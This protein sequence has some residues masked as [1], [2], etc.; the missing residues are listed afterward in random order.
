ML[1]H[2]Q[3]RITSSK[4]NTIPERIIRPP[5]KTQPEIEGDSTEDDEDLDVPIKT[6]SQSSI[7]QSQSQSR[8]K[9]PTIEEQSGRT[10][11]SP[12]ATKKVKGFRIG[13]KSKNITAK[14][15]SPKR[16]TG[17]LATEVAD[18]IPLPKN[19][20]SPVPSQADVTPKKSKKVFK[21]GGKGKAA[22]AGSSQVDTASSPVQR[23]RATQSPTAEPPSSPPRP[24]PIKEE[25]P[26]PEEALEETAEEK[27]ERRRAELKRKTEEAAK[28]QAQNK[29][30][31][32][33]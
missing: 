8:I 16:N 3:T 27:A 2:S 29:K 1:N 21:I 12:P 32:R 5:Q 10:R 33:F 24:A 25:S 7:K 15:P 11:A 31:R 6:K 23:T 13:G 17:A 14:S 19:R 9:S 26:I 22:Q 28:K 4:P 18:P 30:K 20:L